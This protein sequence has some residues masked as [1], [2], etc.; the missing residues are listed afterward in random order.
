MVKLQLGC[1]CVYVCARVCVFMILF[2]GVRARALTVPEKTHLRVR[3]HTDFAVVY[4]C[5]GVLLRSPQRH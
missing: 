4:R 1:V 2:V 3:T 5:L